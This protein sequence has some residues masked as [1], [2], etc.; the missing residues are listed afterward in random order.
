[1]LRGTAGAHSPPDRPSYSI[2]GRAVAGADESLQAELRAAYSQR[3]T[4]PR[5]RCRCVPGGVEMY[6]ARIATNFHLKRMPGTGPDHAWSCPSFEPPAGLSGLGELLGSAISEDPLDGSTT[7]KLGFPL[8]KVARKAPVIGEGA[9]PESVATTGSRLSLRDLLHYLW[10]QAGFNRWTPAMSGKRSWSVVRKY[11]LE[12]AGGMT[13]KG[14]GLA[15][16]LF[17]PEPWNEQRKDEQA[18]RRRAQLLR[19]ASAAKG[20][21]RLMLLLGEVRRIEPSRYGHRLV[22]KHAP[23][24]EFA[25]N[26]D[27]YK[28]MRRRFETELAFWDAQSHADQRADGHLMVFGTFSVSVT[29]YPAMEELVL[30]FVTQNWIPVEDGF[31]LALLEA[32]TRSGHRFTRSLRY[33]LA[34]SQALATAVMPDTA[35]APTALYIAR[36]GADPSFLAKAQEMAGNAGMATWLWETAEADLPPLPRREA[37][38]VGAGHATGGATSAPADGEVF[39]PWRA[40]AGAAN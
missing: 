16:L 32:L 20:A 36:S 38:A 29:G 6:I 9:E 30:M 23:E 24:V 34:P 7:L 5:P 11:L 40:P 10:E 21:R 39:N 37:P 18:A 13:A 8:T 28:A 12:A 15:A 26:E 17:V 22:V 33:N 2:D 19:M 3:A 25:L 1:M 27:I 31:D 14:A 4:G 35:P